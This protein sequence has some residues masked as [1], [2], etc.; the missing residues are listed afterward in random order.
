MF[1]ADV[2]SLSV[3]GLIILKMLP[4]TSD[5]AATAAPADAPTDV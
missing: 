4:R 1:V 3:A 2:V 5:A